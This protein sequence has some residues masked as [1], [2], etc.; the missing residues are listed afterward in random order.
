MNK[1]NKRSAFVNHLEYIR[2]WKVSA[3]L[4]TAAS[5]VVPPPADYLVRQFGR[6]VCATC[7]DTGIC[8]ECYGEYPQYCAA[9]CGDGTCSCAAGVARR[10]AYAAAANRQKCSTPV[11]VPLNRE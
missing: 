11:V 10:A 6:P 3:D 8:P 5:P 7:W 2:Q 4:F 1:H 9:E